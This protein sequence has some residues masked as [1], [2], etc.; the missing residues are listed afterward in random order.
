[1]WRNIATLHYSV[2]T[3][4]TILNRT[5]FISLIPLDN[6]KQSQNYTLQTSSLKRF[7][8]LQHNVI[9]FTKLSS[10]LTRKINLPSREKKTITFKMVLLALT[11]IMQLGPLSSR[12]FFIIFET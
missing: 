8:W 1:M 3:T 2:K 6:N 9:S 7:P 11:N 10:Y 12:T 4:N 5:F